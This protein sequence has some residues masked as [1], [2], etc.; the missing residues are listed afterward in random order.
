M[1]RKTY[2]LTIPIMLLLLA[3]L[4]GCIR[5]VAGE[6]QVYV[7]PDIEAALEKSEWTQVYVNLTRPPGFELP[8]PEATEDTFRDF[9]ESWDWDVFEQLSAEVRA[10]ILADL[11]P[12]DFVLLGEFRGPAFGGD[13]S[14]SGLEKLRNHPDAVAINWAWGGSDDV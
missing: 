9:W 5:D 6:V 7:D 1:K 11:G 4:A 3:V 2:L 14:A 10:R 12:E 13:I 8:G